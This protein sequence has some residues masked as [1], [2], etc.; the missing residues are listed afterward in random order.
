MA[1]RWLGMA[2]AAAMVISHAGPASAYLFWVQ[3]NF[4]G[5]PVVGDEPGISLSDTLPTPL[6]VR[7]SRPPSADGSAT[8]DTPPAG[9]VVQDPTKPS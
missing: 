3:P 4:Q 6:S 2:A 1:F 7:A 9:A 8:A 5:G